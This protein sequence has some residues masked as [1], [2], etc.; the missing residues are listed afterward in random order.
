[1]S[2]VHLWH[3][4]ELVRWSDQLTQAVQTA[5][6]L[7]SKRL[8]AARLVSIDIG[9]PSGL[10]ALQEQSQRHAA[11]LEVQLQQASQ[12][13]LDQGGRMHTLLAEARQQAQADSWCAAMPL[14]VQCP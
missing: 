8:Q 6:R 9:F 7:T 4:N 5:N 12:V 11:E 10:Q 13:A 2:Q 1:M 3:C 14:A